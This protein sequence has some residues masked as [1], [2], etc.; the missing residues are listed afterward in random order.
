MFCQYCGTDN[1][2]GFQFCGKC[3]AE[4]KFVYQNTFD[5]ED[6]ISDFASGRNRADEAR[7][8]AS[9]NSSVNMNWNPQGNGGFQKNM[10]VGN[11]NPGNFGQQNQ[12]FQYQQTSMG[13]Q[14]QQFTQ[15]APRPQTSPV[16][17]PAS[18]SAGST[19]KGGIDASVVI[20]IISCLALVGSIFLPAVNNV[21]MY[22]DPWGRFLL[23]SM[24]PVLIC[25]FLDKRVIAIIESSI[26]L[27]WLVTIRNDIDR[28]VQD[29]GASSSDIEYQSGW[30]LAWGFLLVLFCAGI[31]GVKKKSLES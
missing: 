1:P 14:S 7:R 10:N 2:D 30:Y 6:T 16:T 28:L 11:S 18:S 21:T 24:V 12:S 22:S 3:G 29:Y 13:Q 31:W 23:V 20:A 5:E 8:S 17:K 4:L 25:L 19:K 15:S 26:F 9:N 27:A